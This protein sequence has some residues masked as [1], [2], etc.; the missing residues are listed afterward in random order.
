VL[1]AVLTAYQHSGVSV[2]EQ[3]ETM[4]GILLGYSFLAVGLLTWFTA[5]LNAYSAGQARWL[6][7]TRY[8]KVS[9]ISRL[10]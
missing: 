2:S 9:L 5:M 4:K 8:A 7:A 3:N 1:L 6:I 10:P